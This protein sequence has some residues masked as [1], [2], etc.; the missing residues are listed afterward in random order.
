[1]SI[2]NKESMVLLRNLTQEYQ[3]RAWLPS[4]FLKWIIPFQGLVKDKWIFQWVTPNRSGYIINDVSWE[5]CK[6]LMPL[7]D[8]DI[9]R[10]GTQKS[11][12]IAG[13]KNIAV[14][15][16]NKKRTLTSVYIM[17]LGNV[18]HAIQLLRR[19]GQVPLRSFPKLLMRLCFAKCVP[20][21][22]ITCLH[23]ERFTIQVFQREIF[24][25]TGKASL[26]QSPYLLSGVW[27]EGNI[28]L[29]IWT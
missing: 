6:F 11:R 18:T 4:L 3:M 27:Y 10:N 20:S 9:L 29:H 2:S 15:K 8:C 26:Q 17:R 23:L 14:V 25:S 19:F 12:D 28:V 1:M 24:P 16:I 21:P 7:V 13:T 5:F 22:K